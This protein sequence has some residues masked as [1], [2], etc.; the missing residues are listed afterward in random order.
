MGGGVG[1][2]VGGRVGGGVGGLVGGKVV[3]GLVGDFVGGRDGAVVGL[4]TQ[5]HE[6]V[7]TSH[8]SPPFLRTQLVV[9]QHPPFVKNQ[10]PP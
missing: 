2:G 7:Y 4:S 8:E 3:G 5:T 1:A 6:S 10:Y 9:S